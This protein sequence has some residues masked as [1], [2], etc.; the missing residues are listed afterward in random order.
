MQYVKMLQTLKFFFMFLYAKYQ[1]IVFETGLRSGKLKPVVIISVILVRYVLLPPIGVAVVKLA[2]YL[3]FLPQ[4]PLYH[5]VL[6]IQFT[7][8]P[9]MNIGMHSRTI[10]SSPLSLSPHIRKC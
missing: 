9:A 3:G 8:P 7:V 5:F 6:M 1:Y 4:D 10:A 2:A